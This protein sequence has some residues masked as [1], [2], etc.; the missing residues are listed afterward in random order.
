MGPGCHIDALATPYGSICGAIE[1]RFFWPDPPG[2]DGDVEAPGEIL[3][4]EP[5]D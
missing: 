2:G 3:I 5:V 1:S 4:L